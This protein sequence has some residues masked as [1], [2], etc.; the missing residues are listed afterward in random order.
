M[1]TTAEIRN[2]NY[3][4]SVNLISNIEKPSYM[5]VKH[6]VDPGKEC[7]I[8]TNKKDHRS[9]L[10]L[11]GALEVVSYQANENRILMTFEKDNGWHSSAGSCYQ[12]KNSSDTVA[13]VLEAGSINGKDIEGVCLKDFEYDIDSFCKELSYYSVDKPWGGEIWY[14]ENLLDPPYALKRISMNGGNRSSLQ[15]HNEK[16]ETNYVIAGEAELLYGMIAPDDMSAEIDISKLKRKKYGPHTGFSSTRRE[17]HRVIAE[18]DYVAIEVSTPELDD[19]IRWQDDSNRSHGRV[20]T[21]HGATKT[22]N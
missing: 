17:I 22:S 15:S 16:L 6:T 20:D 3:G 18:V 7:L 10:V 13:I 8:R 11:G 5:F 2:T 19:V 12:F 14:T 1:D 21:E 4:T 9:F